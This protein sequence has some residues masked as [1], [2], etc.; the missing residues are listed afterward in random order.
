M[1]VVPRLQDYEHKYRNVA[2]ERRDGILQM[3]LH[4]EGKDLVWVFRTHEELPYCFADVAADP[5]NKV[6]ILTGTGDTFID[7]SDMDG[8]TFTPR[9]WGEKALFDGKRIIM[10]LLDIPA[11]MIAAVNGPT[12]LHAELA[13][14][15]DVV[16]AADHTFFQDGP[17]FP[18]GLLPGDGVHVVFPLLM[19]LNRARYFMIT[20]QK[21]SAAEALTL[22]LVNEVMPQ[23]KLLPRA[24]A[25]AREILRRPPLTVR[26]HREILLQP[27]KRAMLEHLPYGLALEGLGVVDWWPE[28]FGELP[29]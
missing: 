22:G 12:S 26:L 29:S 5:E 14:L 20:G 10:N 3:T 18:S 11:P 8:G 25:L 24:W 28:K 1:S 16:L 2:F 9:Q 4:T 13:L 6:I 23:D 17:H 15:C 21:L 19:G 27:V 7:R